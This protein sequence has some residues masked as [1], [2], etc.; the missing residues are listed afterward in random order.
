MIIEI[1]TQTGD[2]VHVASSHIVC[3]HLP[4]FTSLENGGDRQPRVMCTSNIAI[5]VTDEE[6]RRVLSVWGGAE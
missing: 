4:A 5:G 3:V 1:H 6:A 2:V